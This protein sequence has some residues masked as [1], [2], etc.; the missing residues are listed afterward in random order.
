MEPLFS[1]TGLLAMQTGVAKLRD[2]IRL[3]YVFTLMA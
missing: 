1:G 2:I 3:N